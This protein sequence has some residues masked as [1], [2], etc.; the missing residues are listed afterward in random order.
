MPRTLKGS[1]VSGLVGSYIGQLVPRML[2]TDC[3]FQVKNGG[4]G[5]R[6]LDLNRH[7]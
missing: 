5:A 7:F 3:D 4:L 2:R 6:V 1:P